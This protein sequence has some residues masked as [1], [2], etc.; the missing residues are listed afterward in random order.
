MK[1]NIDFLKAH[2]EHSAKHKYDLQYNLLSKGTGSAAPH[3]SKTITDSDLHSMFL[4]HPVSSYSCI[5]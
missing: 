3:P 5:W 1:I 2:A 4:H